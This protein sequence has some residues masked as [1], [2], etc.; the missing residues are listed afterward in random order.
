MEV[1]LPPVHVHQDRLVVAVVVPHVV[2]G[3]LVPVLDLSGRGIKGQGGVGVEVVTRAVDAVPVGVR[4]ADAPVEGV[5]F[6]IVRTGDPCRG[7]T[8][9]GGFR[10][11]PAVVVRLTRRGD[12]VAPPDLFTGFRVEGFDVEPGR[13]FRSGH[14]HDHVA[15]YDERGD[16]HRVGLFPVSD[17]PVPDDFPG[18]G[19]EGHHVRVRRRDED[20][21]AVQRDPAVADVAAHVAGDSLRDLVVVP[22]DLVA[23]AG[24]D[25]KGPAVRSGRVHHPVVHERRGVLRVENTER[26]R[27]LGHQAL[28]RLGIDLGQRAVA[29][30][31]VVPWRHEP[32]VG[33]LGCLKQHLIG[34]VVLRRSRARDQ[35]YRTGDDCSQDEGTG[36][37]N[38][39]S[40]HCSF[41][42]SRMSMHP[43]RAEHRGWERDAKKRSTASV[44]LR[45]GPPPFPGAQAGAC[46]GTLGS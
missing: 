4:V 31:R 5:E 24:I 22:P 27:P 43:Q 20:L 21:V 26:E 44:R 17:V 16:G 15:L 18:L 38:G 46:V 33:I 41:L 32:V 36:R 1:E 23:G 14:P 25:R 39:L 19:V 29:G 10:T 8:V 40:G 7:P 34:Y 13:V 9:R 42:P 6:R 35:C 11:A 12:G 3:V 45:G 30:T 2:W 37:P 28:D